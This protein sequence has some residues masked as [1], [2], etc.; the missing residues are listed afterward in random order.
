VHSADFSRPASPSLDQQRDALQKG[1]GRAMQWAMTRRLDD[2]PL[3]AACLWDQRYDTQLEETRVIW[4][5][6][7]VRAVDAVDRFRVPI[8]HA[9]YELSDDRSANQLCELA[10][11][12]AEAGDEAFRNRLY[13]IV[14]Q[15]PVADGNCV[16]EEEI[17]CLD[18]EK[19]FLFAARIRGKQLA[20][21]EWEWD[22]GMLV[23]CAIERCGEK[24]VADVLEQS[25]DPAI[26]LFRDGWREQKRAEAEHQELPSQR[27]RMREIGTSEIISKAE[28]C[29]CDYFH[30]RG[31]GM[32]A[33]E[34]DLEVV[35]RQLWKSTDPH[36]ISNLLEVFSNRPLPTFDARLIELCEHGDSEVRRCA[37]NALENNEHALI[38]AFGLSQLEKGVCDGLVVGLFVRNFQRG[39]EQ[40][41]LRVLELPDDDFEHH[42]LLMSV[43]KVLEN[44]PEADVAQLAIIAYASTRC[45]F[46]RRGS[47]KLLIR[48]HVAPEWLTEECRFDAVEGCRE[49]VVDEIP[50]PQTRMRKVDRGSVARGE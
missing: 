14:E 7:M 33:D 49:L 5:W 21:R 41:I 17:I 22:D 8:L 45:G 28:S 47:A 42:S 43:I 50:R 38:R 36:V 15:K 37:F 6:E 9:L 16:G 34:A 23:N 27:D 29:E 31:W 39:D 18:G 13:E 25:T 11:R 3:L 1:L 19:A 30:F 32:H 12:Y 20:N 24:R 2:E 35:L 4:L 26:Q 44:N 40:R 10:R 46:C 48:Q